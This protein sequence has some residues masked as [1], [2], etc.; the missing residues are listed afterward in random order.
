MPFD[1]PPAITRESRRLIQEYPRP[2]RTGGVFDCGEEVRHPISSKSRAQIM[3]RAEALERSIK[4]FGQRDGV[5]GPSTPMVRRG[6]YRAISSTSKAAASATSSADNGIVLKYF[7]D[8]VSTDCQNPR[9]IPCCGA[10]SLRTT[11]I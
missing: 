8:S 4:A 9:T 11:I 2:W 3:E 10:E 6:R 7:K 1:H 5:L